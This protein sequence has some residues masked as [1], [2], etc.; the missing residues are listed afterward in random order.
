GGD[1]ADAADEARLAG[2]VPEVEAGGGEQRGGGLPSAVGHADLL[3]PATELVEVDDHG[4]P[5]GPGAGRGV[6]RR[7]RP[8]QPCRHGQAGRG[9][10][11]EQDVDGRPHQRRTR[12]VSLPRRL[13]NWP[14]ATTFTVPTMR[15][16]LNRTLRAP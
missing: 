8:D 4:H 6:C 7:C 16:T 10:E 11:T 3:D 15:P 12:K 1:A 2:G 9:G 13:P 14:T 5:A